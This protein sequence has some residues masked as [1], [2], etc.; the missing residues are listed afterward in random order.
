[1]LNWTPEQG[2][3]P[4]ESHY[5]PPRL[6]S[7]L[8]LGYTEPKAQERLDAFLAQ[9][10]T[11]LVDIRY[12]PRSRWRPEFNQSALIERY[13]ALK[14]GHCRELGN[15]NYNKPGEPIKLLEPERGI[16]QTISLLQNGRSLTLL[17]ACKNYYECHRRIAYNLII[18]ALNEMG[19]TIWLTPD[20]L[21]PGVS[22]TYCAC[23]MRTWHQSWDNGKVDERER[24]ECSYKLCKTC[25][26][27][28]DCCSC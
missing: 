6:G 5:E 24:C 27:C 12:S 22:I 3:L 14:Y 26:K 21:V 2:N 13:G 10:H 1:M 23:C 8:T 11:G 28:E 19:E 15:V 7:L 9:P 17:C 18:T 16:R 25:K 4:H 20:R